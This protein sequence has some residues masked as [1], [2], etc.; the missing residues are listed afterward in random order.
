MMRKRLLILTVLTLCMLLLCGCSEKAGF[1]MDEFDMLLDSGAFDG[2][3]M[4]E[5][6]QDLL[7]GLYGVDPALIVKGV[8][9]LASNTSVSADELVLF[10]M[11][12]NDD[13]MAAEAAA[14]KRIEAQLA[15]CR[16]YCPDAVPRLESA[17]VERRSNTVL[18]A[19]GDAGFIAELLAE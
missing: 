2:S 14:N 13:A 19:V 10:M 8:G 16:T 18:V 5:L 4:E 3:D 1:T 12:S 9:C 6:E 17:L 7:A 15:M 11:N